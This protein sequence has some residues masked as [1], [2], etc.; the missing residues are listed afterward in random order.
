MESWGQLSEEEAAQQWPEHLKLARRELQQFEM[1][2]SAQEKVLALLTKTA[3]AAASTAHELQR[4]STC[5]LL[6]LKYSLYFIL[7]IQIDLALLGA[8]LWEGLRI[9]SRRSMPSAC[10]FAV[11][12]RGPHVLDSLP[13]SIK[14]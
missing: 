2:I 1:L 4:C 8:C 5:A 10:L 9:A 13:N 6:S 12:F 14:Y 11:I 7:I 3:Q